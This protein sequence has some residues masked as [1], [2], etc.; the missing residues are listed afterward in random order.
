MRKTFYLA[1]VLFMAT[2]AF[3]AAHKPEFALISGNGEQTVKAGEKI[4]TMVFQA[5]YVEYVEPTV[6]SGL[7]ISCPEG[8][9]NYEEY[10]TCKLFGRVTSRAPSGVYNVQLGPCR[11][12]IRG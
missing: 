12:L 2:M 10:F 7:E 11:S 4:E 6:L 3:A 1:F 9:I 8:P 5:R